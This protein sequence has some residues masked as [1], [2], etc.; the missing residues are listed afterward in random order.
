MADGRAVAA[1]FGVGQVVAD[2]VLLDCQA[3]GW[4]TWSEFAGTGGWSLTE[5]GRVENERQ[6]AAELAGLAEPEEPGEVA[7]AEPGEVAGAEPGE[8]ADA[9][10]VREAYRAFLSLN[11][12]LQ[13]ACTD[14]QI[15]PT[16]DDSLAF[17]DHS[18]LAWDG[19]VIDELAALGHAL[20]AVSERLTSVLDR[21]QGYDTRFS[22]ALGRVIAGD[23]SWVDRT[24]ADSCHTVW[25][26]LH[27]DLIATLGL[28]RGAELP[29]E[30]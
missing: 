19:Q 23:S 2:D 30:N 24:G 17:N 13:R 9:E 5:A 8:V 21:F 27:E 6:L 4:V 22:T 11:E 26:E 3:F 10:V 16:A 12:R 25:F 18:D 20:E 7:G 28:A 14:W 29:V 1:R 15:R